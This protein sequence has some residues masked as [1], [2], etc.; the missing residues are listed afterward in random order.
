MP[1]ITIM[2]AGF[3]GSALGRSFNVNGTEVSFYDPPKGLDDASVLQEAEII[4]IAVPSGQI[5]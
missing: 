4:F 3:V 2:G 5:V 1:R